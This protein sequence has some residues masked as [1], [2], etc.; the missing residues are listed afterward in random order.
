MHLNHLFSKR[1]YFHKSFSTYVIFFD[2]GYDGNICDESFQEIESFVCTLYGK[3]KLKS[4]NE[5]RLET[6][7]EKY[8]YKSMEEVIT[9]VKKMDGSSLP[10][11]SKALEQKV[12]QTSYINGKWLSAISV[13]TRRMWLGVN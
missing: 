10:P 4:V 5:C 8:N 1:N 7:L 12:L 11:C 3:P 9:C 2:M 13:F 6:F